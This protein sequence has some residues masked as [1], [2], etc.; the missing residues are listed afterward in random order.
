MAHDRLHHA[1]PAVALRGEIVDGVAPALH[2]LERGPADGPPVVLLH[3]LASLAQE[4]LTPLAGPLTGAGY[5][6]IAFD[7]P[8]Y[9]FSAPAGPDAMSPRDQARAVAGAMASIGA[10]G[11]VIVG[12]SFGA[13]P[14]LLLGEDPGA[15]PAGLVL[16]SP[17]CRPTRPAAAPGLRAANAPGIGPLI[18]SALPRIA[19]PLGRRMVRAGLH[20]GQAAPNPTAFPWRRMAQGSAVQ[21]MAGELRGFNADMTALRTRLKEIRV[22]TVILADP[23]D[24]VIPMKPHVRWLTH[25]MPE[26]TVRWRAAGHLLHHA[27]PQAVVAAVRSVDPAARPDVRRAG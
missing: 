11:A 18:R 9:G 19:G 22:P 27:D 23:E 3:G 4:M 26:A 1:P 10:S 5:R 25:R 17:F 20:A 15:A 21:A 14:A 13:A 12:H 6:A 24:P 2:Y 8:G 16:I 7:R